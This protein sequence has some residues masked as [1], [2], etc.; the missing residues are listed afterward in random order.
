MSQNTPSRTDVVPDDTEAALQDALAALVTAVGEA[1]AAGTP[2]TAQI[3]R[4][5]EIHALVIDRQAA[6]AAVP[7]ARTNALIDRFARAVKRKLARAEAKHGWRN[8]WARDDWEGEC[9]SHLARHLLKGDPLDVAAYAAF[10]WHHAWP[11]KPVIPDLHQPSPWTMARAFE[12]GFCWAGLVV[13]HLAGL[14]WSRDVGRTLTNP[15]FHGLP[16]D[17]DVIPNDAAADYGVVL[18]KHEIVRALE[19]LERPRA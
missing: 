6:H 4:L 9:R 14:G 15:M 13:D 18:A 12:V 5:R 17:L 19:S 1:V 10:C 16:M 8:A 11:T 7:H 3:A 2:D